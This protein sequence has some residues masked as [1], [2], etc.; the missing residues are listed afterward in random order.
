[1]ASGARAQGRADARE[2][3]LKTLI[4]PAPLSI[5]PSSPAEQEMSGSMVSGAGAQG[6]ANAREHA[7]ETLIGPVPLSINPSSPAEQEMSGNLL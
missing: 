5:N 7:L 1:M 3:A 6:R 2:H 4:A